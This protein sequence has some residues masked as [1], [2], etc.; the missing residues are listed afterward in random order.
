[1]PV[2]TTDSFQLR[3]LPRVGL[4]DCTLN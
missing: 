1:V 3:L 2:A 4:T